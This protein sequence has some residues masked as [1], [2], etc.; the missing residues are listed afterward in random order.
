M[1]SIFVVA[2]DHG[3]EGHSAPV[4]AFTDESSAR[5][6]MALLEAS[7]M[8]GSWQL[9]SVPIWPEHATIYYD[10]KPVPDRLPAFEAKTHD[11]ILRPLTGL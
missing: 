4:Q 5:A 7:A 1:S 6:A 9:Y 3:Y 8:G 2:L 10:I 11:L